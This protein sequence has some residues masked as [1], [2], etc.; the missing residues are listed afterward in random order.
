[1]KMDVMQV[2]ESADRPCNLP[3]YLHKGELEPSSP[4][5]LGRNSNAK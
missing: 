4:R 5:I 1:M 3:R 2:V